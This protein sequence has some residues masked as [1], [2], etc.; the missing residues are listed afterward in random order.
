MSRLRSHLLGVVNLSEFWR[1][2]PDFTLSIPASAKP[3]LCAR[4]RGVMQSLSL[5]AALV[6]VA[7]LAVVVNAVELICTAG[8]GPAPSRQRLPGSAGPSGSHRR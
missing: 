3:G 1:K 7:G 5:P 4:M 6:A 2:V 8:T